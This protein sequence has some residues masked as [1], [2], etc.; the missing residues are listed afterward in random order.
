MDGTGAFIRSSPM[1]HRWA[2]FKTKLKDF[3][4][5]IA[6][7]RNQDDRKYETNRKR[8]IGERIRGGG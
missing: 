4:S 6:G 2:E 7:R 8:T 1:M 3:A 5:P